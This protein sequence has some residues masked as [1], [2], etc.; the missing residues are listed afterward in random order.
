MRPLPVAAVAAAAVA[1]GRQ[2]AM[3]A[4]AE[5][6]YYVA[7]LKRAPNEGREEGRKERDF[8]AAAAAS[9]R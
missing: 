8:D 2:K 4:L 6:V 5:V 9:A 1:M 7:P 3:F